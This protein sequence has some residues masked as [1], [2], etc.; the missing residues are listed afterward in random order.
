MLLPV[1]AAWAGG[2]I[3]GTITTEDGDKFTGPIRW[4]KNENFWDDI[5]DA[6]KRD[7]VFSHTASRS[8]IRIFGL[9]FGDG[10]GGWTNSQLT[11][12]FGNIQSI[13]PRR[14]DR[15]DITLKSGEV[16][17]LDGSGTDLGED[18]RE[19][20]IDD[21]D[22]GQI[23]MSWSEIEQID[24]SQGPGAGLDADRLYGTVQTSDGPLTGYIVWDRDEALRE[25]IMDGD[26]DGDRKKV[27]FA[28]IRSIERVGSHSRLT[29]TSGRTMDLDGT[30]DVDDGNRGID[31]TIPGMGMVTVEWRD[32][33]RVDFAEPPPSVRY[34]TFN[35]GHKLQGTVKDDYGTPHTGEI[36]WDNDEEYT[37]EAI[38]GKDGDLDYTVILENIKAIKRHSRRAAEIELKN[39]QVLRLD[40]SNDV[41][42]SNKGIRIKKLD[43]DEVEL[44]WDEFESV[45]F[46]E[47]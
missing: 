15:V 35:G 6:E 22:E 7:K 3:Y 28:R 12:Q 17:K 11:I 14:G 5:L 2:E 25:D 41:D 34:E 37:W 18:M 9:S 43:G 13:R 32:F 36:V 26:E 23:E 4:D 44:D 16:L 1:C 20:L 31:V 42:D 30:N 47:P 38:D 29:L 8:R 21:S 39:G 33:D 24:F 40:D 46:T 19:L 10:D 27:P 45:E